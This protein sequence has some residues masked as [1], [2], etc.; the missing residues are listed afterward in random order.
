VSPPQRYVVRDLGASLGKTTTSRLL[1]ILPIPARGFGQG[2]RN[3]IGDFE[4]QGFI[5]RVDEN[6]VDFDFKAKI[7]EGLAVS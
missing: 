3:N 7:A 4:S 5:N 2:S 1:W 6:K